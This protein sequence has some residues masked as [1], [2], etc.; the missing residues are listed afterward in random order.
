MR[1][2]FI[3]FAAALATFSLASA[4]Q[5]QE[6]PSTSGNAF[7]RLCTV[8]DKTDPETNVDIEHAVACIGYVE[9]VVQGIS[10]EANY[11][12]AMTNQEPPRPF[13]LPENSDN[14]QLIR[15][16]LKYIRNHPEKAH[17]QTSLLATLALRDAFPCA[18]HSA[19]KK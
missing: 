12:H 18:T 3:A 5:P 9:G 1:L 4:Q 16:V 7:Q 2:A 6:F 15:V 11:A 10:E 8:I 19:P 13:C 14:G 17:L